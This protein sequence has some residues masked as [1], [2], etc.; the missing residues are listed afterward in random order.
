MS[1]LGQ[2]QTLKRRSAVSALPPNADILWTTSSL[3]VGRRTVL[4]AP[5]CQVVVSRL[6][7][8]IA[9]FGAQGRDRTT[10]TRIFS[11]LLYQLSYL[12]VVR[13]GAYYTGAIA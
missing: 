9:D 1:A 6:T 5:V 11:P 2:K 7:Q 12:A 8:E 3:A 4:V 13:E 10:D